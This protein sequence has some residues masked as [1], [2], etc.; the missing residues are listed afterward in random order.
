MTQPAID[1]TAQKAPSPHAMGDSPDVLQH[2]SRPDVNLSLWRRP[3]QEAISQELSVLQASH[4]PEGRYLTTFATFD[5]DVCAVLRAHGLEPGDFEHFRADLNLLAAHFFRLSEGRKVK[6]RLVTTDGDNCRRFHVD[7]RH[8]R[9]LC[10]YRGPGTEWLSNAQVDRAALRSGAPNEAILRFGE[11]S[12]MAP[13]WVG[14][15]K[16]E[17]DKVG[18]GLVHR[19]PPIAGSGQT[20]VL[21]CLDAEPLSYA[22][23]TH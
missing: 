6:F 9:L 23:R 8:L 22:E 2:V 18:N 20:R 11:P 10:T 1:P 7:T 14:I 12:E 19:S 13:F 15:M 16:G 4:L 17:L 21:F 3:Q 5:D